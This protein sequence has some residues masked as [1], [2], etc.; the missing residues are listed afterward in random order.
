[1]INLMPESSSAPPHARKRYKWRSISLSLLFAALFMGAA[2]ARKNEIPVSL[3]GALAILSL[4]ALG[5]LVYEFIILM[6]SLD[7]LQGRLH[8]TALAIGFGALMLALFL[9]GAGTAF[10]GGQLDS[11]VLETVMVLS[12]PAGLIAY[13]IA[14]HVI[15][16]RYR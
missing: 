12:L 4:I 1:M 10:T 14:L 13:Y 8:V 3:V 5:A 16:R 11:E 6:R 2:L 15:L 9:L 7:E